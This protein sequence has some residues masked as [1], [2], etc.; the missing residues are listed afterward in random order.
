MAPFLAVISEAM[1]EGA[2]GNGYSVETARNTVFLSMCLVGLFTGVTFY[3]LGK[4]R[5][6]RFL[7]FFPYPVCLLPVIAFCIRCAHFIY[8]LWCVFQ[9][10]RGCFAALG[11]QMLLSAWNLTVG[12][13]V[14]R[15]VTSQIIY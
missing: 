9:V 14:C 7:Q 3:L 2:D 11:L 12:F 1:F 6:G 5:V 4:F 10:S 8:V 15:R 13:S